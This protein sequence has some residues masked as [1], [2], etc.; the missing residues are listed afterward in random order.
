MNIKFG[1]V[2][3]EFVF[4]LPIMRIS[5]NSSTE[6]V[7]FS[8]QSRDALNLVTDSLPSFCDLYHMNVP[9]SCNS[10]RNC[11]TCDKFQDITA[12]MEKSL[13]KLT[14][15]HLVLASKP[16]LLGF[17]LPVVDALLPAQNCDQLPV[18]S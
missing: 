15:L 7:F 6:M 18:A 12:V 1:L 14:C 3:T 11:L 9:Q 10:T 17:I 5:T 13:S 8:S 16:D 2:L 4:C